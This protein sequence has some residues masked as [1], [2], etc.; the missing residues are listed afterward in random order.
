MIITGAPVEL[1][2]FEDV[3]LLGRAVRD[4]MDCQ[5]KTSI[6]QCLSAGALRPAFIIITAL[7][8]TLRQKLCGVFSHEIL[9]PSHP[10]IRG[11]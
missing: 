8:N 6:P 10:L 4:I 11:I 9:L 3:G 1:M 7:K 5:E 2:E